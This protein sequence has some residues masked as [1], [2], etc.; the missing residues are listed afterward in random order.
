M[1]PRARTVAALAV[2]LAAGL[3]SRRIDSLPDLVEDHAGDALWATAV[4]LALSILWSRLRAHE[5]ALVGFGIAVVVEV[6]QL[7]KPGWL[8][9]LRDNDLAALF[10]GRGFLWTNLPRYGVLTWVGRTARS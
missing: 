2:V 8:V 10:L 6:S 4:V 3:G 9:D 1:T 7:W 5:A